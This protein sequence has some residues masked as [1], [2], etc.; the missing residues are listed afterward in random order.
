MARLDFYQ[1]NR[2][3]SFISEV[4][5]QGAPGIV[6]ISLSKTTMNALRI[7]SSVSLAAFSG[8]SSGRMS[9]MNRGAAS[10]ANI[11]CSA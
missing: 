2:N 8:A 5:A 10:F 1:P 9:V 11:R 7:A 3:V 6:V 4:L